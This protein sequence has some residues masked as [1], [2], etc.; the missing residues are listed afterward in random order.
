MLSDLNLVMLGPPGAGKGTQAERLNEQIAEAKRTR[1]GIFEQ[2]VN[3]TFEE[4]GAQAVRG[5]REAQAAFER[6]VER[7]RGQPY[8]FGVLE[9]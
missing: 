3:M 9:V 2:C 6:I 7:A 8:A 1:H 5:R 4:K